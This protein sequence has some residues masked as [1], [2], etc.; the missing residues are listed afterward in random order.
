MLGVWSPCRGP[1]D[2]ARSSPLYRP[3]SLLPSVALTE[4]F[5][6]AQIPPMFSAPHFVVHKHRK[7]FPSLR[8]LTKEPSQGRFDEDENQLNTEWLSL[9]FKSFDTCSAIV[10]YFVHQHFHLFVPQTANLL[11]Y[12]SG[13][14]S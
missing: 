14:K 7:T 1:P 2:P 5:H 4:G 11:S 6:D 12:E 3:L 8:L 9:Q 10:I 13:T